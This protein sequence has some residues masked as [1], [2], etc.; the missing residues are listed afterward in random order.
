MFMEKS[1][2]NSMTKKIADKKI[3]KSCYKLESG[4]RLGQEGL[5]ACQLGPFSSP[6]YFDEE[7]LSQRVVSKADIVQ[8]R[9]WIFDLLNDPVAVT[10]CKGCSMVIEKPIDEV[11]FDQ[12]GHIDLAAMTT[13]NLRCSFCYYTHHDSFDVA[14]FDA[15]GIL[16]QFD[17][18]DVTWNSAVDFNG[19]E[20]TLLKN[21]DEYLDFFADRKIRVFLYTNG[22]I[23]KQSVV[24]AL[25]N[26]SIRWVIVSLD[27]GTKSTYH[28]TKRSPKFEKVVEN[29]SRYSAA[30]NSDGGQCAVK[31]IFHRDNCSDDDIQGFVFA[32]LAVRP[33]E[34]WLTFD[35]DPL[36]DLSADC[37]D[38]GGN[39]YSLHIEAY[40]KTFLL[41]EKYGVQV[42]HYTEKHLAPASRHGIL[43]LQMVKMR[44]AELRRVYPSDGKLRD[45]R[46]GDGGQPPAS[47][48]GSSSAMVVLDGG[49]LK[50]RDNHKEQ[51]VDLSSKVKSVVLAP[52]S[53]RVLDF[54]GWCRNQG[55][56]VVAIAD[57]DLT[58]IGKQ[59]G[60]IK[61]ISYQ[62]INDM[63]FDGVMVITA[64]SVI[65]PQ[66]ISEVAT[67][68]QQRQRLLVF[69]PRAQISGANLIATDGSTENQDELV[70]WG[71]HT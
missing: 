46:L 70:R 52:A 66:I 53:P 18:H 24:N 1:S 3:V 12:L 30:G 56:D 57:R 48:E 4:L 63:P 13:C 58:L 32:M 21:F 43:L 47:S 38:L 37:N 68:I 31:Y 14:K 65:L 15:L 2:E 35:F 36:S 20:P 54:V 19:G 51:L 6:I 55:I 60:G 11:R 25:E 44:I 42:V 16:E 71:R 17:S 69:E 22:L 28:K 7:E 8:K 59:I 45:F 49:L 39:D 9:K 41:F 50:A 5:H 27:A 23:Y 34:V 26:G 64:N 67:F 10:P 61:V 29:I 33:Q 40:A 62:Q